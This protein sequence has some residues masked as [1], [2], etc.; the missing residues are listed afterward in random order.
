MVMIKI[1]RYLG[2]GLAVA[3]ASSVAQADLSDWVNAVA[4]GTPAKYTST[5]IV[6]PSDV[7]IGVISP[8]PGLTYEFVINC[9]NAGLSSTLMGSRNTGV[10]TNS[11][12]KFEQYADTLSLGITDS[13][14]ADY[15][16]APNI[17]DQD[18]HVAFVVDPA[19][20]TTE[21]FINGVSVAMAPYAPHLT[22][23]V[24]M[25]HWY[26]PG[27]SVDTLT[28]TIYGVAVYETKLTAP[29]LAEHS[30]AFLS[31][32]LGSP[33]C[34]GIGCPCGNDDGV[35]G[36]INSSGSGSKIVAQGS[37]SVG[38]D[39][40]VLLG[41]DIPPGGSAILFSGTQRLNGGAGILF[42]DGLR[43]AGGSLQRLGIRVADGTGNA[44]WGPGLLT[45]ASWAP[46]GSTRTLQIWTAD[47]VNGSCGT[48][49]NTSHGLDLLFAP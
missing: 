5:A 46:T 22:N 35:G 38:T 8:S 31:T 10:G 30:A 20:A 6:V 9:T 45:G 42:G 3:V 26:S 1:R 47:P 37:Q 32:V 28:G 11:A 12:L 15:T 16:M 18:S 27:G 36:C 2:V 14:V 43:C 24:G 7:D 40:L 4:L 48:G 29:E 21:L 17:P 19:A 34:F 39:D 25:G 44:S 49:F 41:S 33:N 13:G 23:L